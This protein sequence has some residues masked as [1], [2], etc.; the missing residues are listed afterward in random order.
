MRLA[1]LEKNAKAFHKQL[2]LNKTHL[3]DARASKLT[4][5]D[6]YVTGRN[7]YNNAG[8]TMEYEKVH[9]H[10]HLSLNRWILVKQV[11]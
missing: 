11:H 2:T 6:M 9:F 5:M 3:C 1:G 7:S 10:K 4:E 8:S